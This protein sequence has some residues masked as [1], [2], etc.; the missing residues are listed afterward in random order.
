MG[1]VSISLDL[2]TE[3]LNIR[4]IFAKSFKIRTITCNSEL[5]ISIEKTIQTEDNV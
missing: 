2:A 1:L 4:E 5:T 3:Y